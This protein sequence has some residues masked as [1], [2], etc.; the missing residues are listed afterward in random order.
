VQLH[1]REAWSS[2]ELP[3]SMFD[4]KYNAGVTP[5]QPEISIAGLNQFASVLPSFKRIGSEAHNPIP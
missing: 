4:E 5:R 2:R 1:G 3:N